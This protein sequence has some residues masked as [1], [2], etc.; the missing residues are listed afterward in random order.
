MSLF[1]NIAKAVGRAAKT[2]APML[3]GPI[4]AVA[5]VVGV[6]SVVA[7]A[8]GSAGALTKALPSIRALP[9][10]GRAVARIGGRVAKGVG[11]AATGYAIYDAAG[12]FLGNKKK[13][14]RINPLNHRALSRALRRIEKVKHAM[15]RVS[16]ITVRKEKC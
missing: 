15:K 10:V 16:A 11:A 12:N 4:G 5:R 9:G 3:P 6:G 1:G 13:H 2:I 7:G 8:T 14:R